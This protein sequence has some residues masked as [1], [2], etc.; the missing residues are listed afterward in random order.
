[1]IFIVILL[2]TLLF[3]KENFL[4]TDWHK[5]IKLN[6]I[7][8][9]S[10]AHNAYVDIYVNKLA[11]STYRNRGS[12]FKEGA[13]VYKPLYYSR[14]KKEIAII[15]IMKKMHKGYDTPHNDWWYGVYDENGQVG[16]HQGRI[17]SC[18]A[19]HAQVPQTD[20]M[21]SQSVMDK[22]EHGKEIRMVLPEH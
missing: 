13:V 18:I 11:E 10:E 12:T 17:K 6:P 3:A 19:C 5:Q 8:L 4:F 14:D 1:M 16:Y 7:V 22:I 20:Y 2:S 21:F 9:E 15:V